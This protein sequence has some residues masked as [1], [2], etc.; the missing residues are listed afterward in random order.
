MNRVVAAFAVLMASPSLWLAGSTAGAQPVQPT[1]RLAARPMWIEKI[2]DGLYIIR[3]PIE[4]GCMLG[5]KPGEKGDGVLHE[6]G[7]TA[8]RV[9]PEGVVLVD[10]KFAQ[11]VPQILA[12]VRSVTAQPVKYLINSH[13]HPDHT[14]GDPEMLKQGVELIQQRYTWDRYEA[15]KQGGATPRVTFDDYFA[16]HLGGVT[17]EAYNFFPTGHTRGDTFVYFP[18]L[19]V[20]HMGDLVIR[21]MPHIDYAGGGGSAV[22]FVSAIY[23][24]L[25][26][27]F[28]VAIPGH[29]A[30][31]TR[32]EIWQYA[33]KMETMNAR[34]KDA[35]RR[36]VPV[37][38]VVPEL[39]LG[40]L[41]WAHSA[42]TTNFLTNDVRGYYAEM[43]AVLEAEKP[44]ARRPR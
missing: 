44:P 43:A 16:L 31:M 27:D 37:D 6:P 20:V 41:G 9:T 14:G 12:L 36:S 26:L 21:G 3:G 1:P 39:G 33:K 40:D 4:V 35:V 5:C 28:D 32:E 42:S 30:P 15:T 29:G 25:K 7:V 10:A 17:V 13:Y 24:L 19:K 2:K 23:Q 22:G 34:M 11:H 38:K 8:A 18:D